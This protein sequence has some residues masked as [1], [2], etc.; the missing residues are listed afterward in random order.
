MKSDTLI[1]SLSDAARVRILAMLFGCSGASALIYEVVWSRELRFLFG[2]TE[3][4]ISTILAGLFIGFSLGAF[5]F[6]ELA[7]KTSRPL[8]HL[9]VLEIAIAVYAISLPIF[10]WLAQRLFLQIPDVTII[11]LGLCLMIVMIPATLLGGLWPFIAQYCLQRTSGSGVGS[12]VIYSANSLGSALGAFAAGFF[13]VPGLGLRNASLSA[14][15]LNLIV[16]GAFYLIHR[17][18]SHETQ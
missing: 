11:R 5:L 3:Q 13:L 18:S 17:Q 7:E 14:A 2:S 8:W 10:V 12:A 9:M 16:A 1:G 6:R 4:T 15:T